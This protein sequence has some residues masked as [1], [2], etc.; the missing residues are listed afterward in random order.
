MLTLF[1]LS[2][3][4]PGPSSRASH[5]SCFPSSA[6]VE[7]ADSS[8]VRMDSVKIGDLVKVAPN[9]FSPV[10]MFTHKLTNHVSSFVTL[11]TASGM[12]LAVSPGH[13]IYANN[14]LVP[15][16]S[17]TTGMTLETSAG[18][19]AVVAVTRAHMTGLFNPQTLHG[20]IVVD[21]VRASTYT[22]AVEPTAAHALLAPFRAAY[23]FLGLSTTALDSGSEALAAVIPA[24]PT[25]VY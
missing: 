18:V 9:T 24:A 12:T 17:V 10:F 25:A 14:A 22:T 2:L 7:L 19:D 3:R 6:T 4:L 23:A 20:D 8:V 15:A 16:S 21:G 5:S 11:T 13:F 1:V